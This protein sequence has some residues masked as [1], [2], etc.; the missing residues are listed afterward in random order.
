MNKKSKKF[1]GMTLVECIVA[2]AV[3]IIISVILI[4]GLSAA[5][6]N[7]RVSQRVNA[8]TALQAPYADNKIDTNN[9]GKAQVKLEYAAVTGIMEVDKY[10]V[11]KNI[12]A[13][14]YVGDYRY[15]EYIPPVTT[16]VTTK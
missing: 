3:L 9:D 10:H 12:K 2:M 11:D 5:V 16:P 15:F 8:K 14:D 7:I 1:K 6:F 4:A 13:Q